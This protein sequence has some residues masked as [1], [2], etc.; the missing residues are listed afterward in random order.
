MNSS[1]KMSK[2]INYNLSSRQQYHKQNTS[3]CYWLFVRTSVTSYKGGRPRGPFPGHRPQFSVNYRTP[4]TFFSFH[5]HRQVIRRNLT[6]HDLISMK[7]DNREHREHLLFSGLLI[8]LICTTNNM[9][10]CVYV[11]SDT[12]NTSKFSS[13][14]IGWS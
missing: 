10:I 6:D 13:Y 7:T 5:R 12:N 2:K 9:G 14:P 8:F 11:K 3:P 4:D 1:L